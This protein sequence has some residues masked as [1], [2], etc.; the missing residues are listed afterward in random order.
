MAGDVHDQERRNAFL[1]SDMSN[2]S[3]KV[4]VQCGIVAEFFAMPELRWRLSVKT[5]ASLCEFDDGGDVIGV[6][7]N[8]DAAFEHAERNTFRFQITFVCADQC[9]KLGAE[10]PIT[11]DATGITTNSAICL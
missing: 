9:G 6:A 8:G 10:W 5:P 7:I 11:E 3:R 4:F 2:S 1:F